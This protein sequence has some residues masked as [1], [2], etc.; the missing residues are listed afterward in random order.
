MDK[1]SIVTLI[2]IFVWNFVTWLIWVSKCSPNIPRT[3]SKNELNSWSSFIASASGRLRD[4][5][6]P[7]QKTIIFISLSRVFFVAFYFDATEMWNQHTAF[8]QPTAWHHSIYRTVLQAFLY[9]R[10]VCEPLICMYKVKLYL[11]NYKRPRKIIQNS[12]RLFHADQKCKRS[13]SLLKCVVEVHHQRCHPA[14]W[15]IHPR[16]MVAPKQ[17]R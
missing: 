10:R 11:R 12:F 7:S 14:Y 17:K 15:L 8:A 9:K 6:A 1:V 5:F 2:R 4:N 13:G 3:L 16:K